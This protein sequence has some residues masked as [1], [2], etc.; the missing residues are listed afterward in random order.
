MNKPLE[1]KDISIGADPEVFFKS[2]L[3]G[4]FVS[5]A[6]KMPGTKKQPFATHFGA[7]Q[8]DGLAAEFNVFPSTDQTTFNDLI[9]EGLE[10]LSRIADAHECSVVFDPVAEFDSDYF[11]SLDADVFELGCEPDFNGLDGM[12]ND[13][14]DIAWE[15][16]RTSSGHVHIG[17][18]K[19][20]P[21]FAAGDSFK[22]RWRLVQH[23]GPQLAR[24]SGQWETEASELRREYYGGNW[25]FRPKPY[26]VELRQLD[27]L[28]LPHNE[29]RREVFNLVQEETANFLCD[30][31][32]HEKVA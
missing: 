22:L 24:I 16:I 14:P 7:V 30:T 15:P 5:C 27:G 29:F 26:G 28:W 1:I 8:V 4:Q 25:A 17:W 2:R 6:G 12:I 9:V 11:Y 19:D 21:D 20:N 31:K 3:T 23:L 10:Y 32:Y 18:E 13:A